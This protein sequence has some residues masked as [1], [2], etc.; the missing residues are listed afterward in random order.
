MKAAAIDLGAYFE[1]I[2]YTGSPLPDLDTVRELIALHTQSIPFENLNPFLGRLVEIDLPSVERKLVREE[3]GGYCYEQNNLF[4]AVL[5]EIGMAVTGLAARVLWQVPESHQ[6]AQSHMMLRAEIAG[7]PYLVDVGFGAQTPTAPLRLDIETEQVTAHGVYRLRR[8]EADYLLQTRIDGN[9]LPVY[10]FD[11]KKQSAGDYKVFNWYCSTHPESRFVNELVAARAF[12]GGRHTLRG[13]EL[14]YYPL[15]GPKMVF[16]LANPQ[17]LRDALADIFKVEVPGGREVE[18]AL[19]GLFA[20]RQE[21][22]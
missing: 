19:A 14:S 3:R 16:R 10:R 1:R 7:V 21:R 6:P 5:Q 2:G 11:L 8:I 15:K 20:S 9:W 4:R 17:E 18:R 22:A 13:R 12:A